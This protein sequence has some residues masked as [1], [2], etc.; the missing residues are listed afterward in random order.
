V[1]LVVVLVEAVL[2]VDSAEV[3]LSEEELEANS[4]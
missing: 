2:V 1:V 3:A 4:K